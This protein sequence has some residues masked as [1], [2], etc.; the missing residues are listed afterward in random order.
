MNIAGV[1]IAISLAEANLV[2]DRWNLSLFQ[3][4]CG[5]LTSNYGRDMATGPSYW[6][7]VRNLVREVCESHHF[8]IS[9]IFD[10]LSDRE[11][12]EELLSNVESYRWLVRDFIVVLYLTDS[13]CWITGNS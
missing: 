11:E 2:A 3:T 12:P 10:G 9:S 1:F 5:L 6:R 7:S 4:L 13:F 8:G